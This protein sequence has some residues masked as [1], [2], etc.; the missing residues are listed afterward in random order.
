MTMPAFPSTPQPAAPTSLPVPPAPAPTSIATPAD[1]AAAASKWWGSSLTIW[2][3][4]I[5]TLATVL[6]VVGPFL[7]IDITADM[8]HQLGTGVAQAI[9]AVGGVVGILMTIYGRV[10]VTQSLMRRSFLMRL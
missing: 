4:F 1:A 2:G 7:G 8:V 10:R 9:Q 3:S 5:T 6:P